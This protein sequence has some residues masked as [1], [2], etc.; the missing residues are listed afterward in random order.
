MSE[1][2]AFLSFLREVFVEKEH[3]VLF[4]P[5]STTFSRATTEVPENLNCSNADDNHMRRVVSLNALALSE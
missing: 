1:V 2:H 5:P 3:C 4:S